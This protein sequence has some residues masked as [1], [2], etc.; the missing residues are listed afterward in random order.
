[1]KERKLV[2]VVSDEDMTDVEF[3]RPPQHTYVVGIGDDVA[4]VRATIHTLGQSI[5]GAELEAVSEAAAPVHL[6]R[7]VQG[8]RDVVCPAD[9][10]ETLVRPD[11]IDVGG[12]VGSPL[13]EGWLIDI[14]LALLM[15]TSVRNI[16]NAD[17]GI[18]RELALDG[19][20]PCP[21]LGILEGFA[22]GGMSPSSANSDRKSTRLNSSHGYISYAVF[23]LK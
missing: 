1:M 3:R 2:Q 15:Q 20:I 9:G 12:G 10:A 6:K 19:D 4:L 16:A 5:G 21:G 23:C 14:G 17:Y 8:V 18:P 13:G 22:L 7:V 11:G